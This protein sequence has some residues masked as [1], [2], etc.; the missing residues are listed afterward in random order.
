MVMFFT[1]EDLESFG[2]YMVSEARKVL[3]SNLY[4]NTEDLDKALNMLNK[5]DFS[6]WFNILNNEN[7]DS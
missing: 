7:H 2:A 5:R 3:Y 4:P 6:D 1:G